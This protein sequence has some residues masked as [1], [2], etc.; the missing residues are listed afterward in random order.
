MGE[1]KEEQLRVD[2]DA[3]VRFE[4]VGSKITSDAGLVAY[5]QLDEKLGLTAMASE[6]LAEQ[7]SGH[8]LR[9]RLI[10]LLRQS[11]YSRLAGYPDT[12][13]ADRLSSDPALR[14]VVSRRAIDKQAAGRST[15]GRVETEILSTDDNRAG[16]A[17]LNGEWISKAMLHTKTQR[18]ILDLDSSESPV[19]GQ[20]EGAKYNGHYRSVC[21]HPLFCFNQ[22]GD[23]EGAMLRHGNVSSAD[24]WRE[25]LDPI[26]T[27]YAGSG[28]RKQFRGDAGFARPEIYEY[29]QEH[30]FVYAIRLPSNAVLEREIEPHLERPQ[31]SGAWHTVVRYHDFF[32]QAGTWDRP[33]RVVAKI[34]WY[35]GELFPRVGF[36]VTNRTDP[37][38]GV[39]EFYNGRGSCEQWIKEGKYALGWMRLSCHQFENNAVR[40]ALF[41]LA[42]NLGNFLRRLVLPAE[43]ASWSLTSLR[44]KLVKIGARLTRHARRLVLQMAEVAVTRDLF[45]QILS[46][47][48]HLKPVP[49]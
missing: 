11:V 19:H 5:R 39:V 28:L 46:R 16:L 3:R 38:R 15:M 33:R 36:I 6:F 35:A 47:I 37:P 1:G 34:E 22:F 7:R 9:H 14:L 20:Q 43:M 8:N 17:V 26:V 42:Y 40:L 32:Y 23:C 21:Y 10:P 24:G 13:D 12:N 45:A 4:F 2:F 18:L 31:E 48:R 44:E 41:V 30:G 27:R 29:L 25:L 49:V